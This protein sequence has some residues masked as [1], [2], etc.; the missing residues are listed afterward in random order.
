MNLERLKAIRS[1]NRG[2]VTKLVHEVEETLTGTAPEEK[3]GRLNVIVE[4]LQTKL[5]VLRKL[6]DDILGLCDVKDIEHEIEEAE[7]ISAKIFECKRR[8]EVFLKP[9]P[10]VPAATPPPTV[11]SMTIRTRLPKLQLPKFRGTAI[12]WLPFWD[13]FKAAV[14]ENPEISTVD[15]FNYLSSLL[16]GPAS[17]V[18][19]ELTLTEANYNAAMTL[20]QERFGDQQVIISAHMELMK[21]PDCNLDCPSSLRHLYD[22]VTIHVR[23]LS[24]LGID[25]KHYGAF[26][27]PVIMQKLP[28]E[29]KLIMARNHPGQVWKIQDLSD[30]IQS[31]VT[32]REATHISRMPSHKTNTTQRPLNPTAS[33]LYAG[34]QPS[35]CV[36]CGGDHYSSMCTTI[37]GDCES[38]KK[39]KHC[40]RKHHQS[41]CDKTA[42]DKPQPPSEP[43]TSTETT[44]NTSNTTREGKLVLLQTARAVAFNDDTGRTI[45]VRVLFDTGS[46]RSYVTDT[47]VSRLN[48][49]PLK[50]EKLQLN[51]FGEPGFK[52][53]GEG[54]FA[55]TWHRRNRTIT[56]LAVSYHLLVCTQCSQSQ[57]LS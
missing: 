40:R 56:S 32:A 16:D 18:V 2:V 10:H 1:A 53:F 22:R 46:Q 50:K 3:V 8:I 33:S 17:K 43:V 15:K 31:E 30:T 6:D 51:T 28:N 21:L 45:N 55:G 27:I 34:S 5:S 52:G 9:A 54:P 26:L 23:G 48:L 24:S 4:Q 25:S 14:H 47:L 29:V 12:D 36:Y 7:E 35:K 39:C 41:I 20:L 44:A 37:T 11:A 57:Q 13:S 19:Q 42:E 38:T 49:K